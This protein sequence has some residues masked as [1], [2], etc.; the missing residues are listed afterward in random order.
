[1]NSIILQSDQLN[2]PETFASKLRGKTVELT[3]DGDAVVIMPVKNRV[4][5]PIK[6]IR[7]VFE[8]DGHE[9][10]RFLE[11]KRAEKRLEYGE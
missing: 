9:V 10:E 8:S 5:R 1:M 6:A 11:R 4:E 7:G 2:L 3:Q